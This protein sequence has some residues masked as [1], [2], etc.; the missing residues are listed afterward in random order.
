VAREGHPRIRDRDDDEGDDGEAKRDLGDPWL[1]ARRQRY[2]AARC[3]GGTMPTVAPLPDLVLYT[4]PG[5][6]LC[7][8][9]RESIQSVLEDRA[10][11]GLPCPAVVARDIETDPDLAATLRARV[12][13]VE[14][15]DR[16]LELA[17]S[18]SRIRRLL[19]DVLDAEMRLA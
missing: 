10:A 14:L 13:V 3:R 9:A 17:V 16:R 15:G 18:P 4:R 12:P 5:C 11:R 19:A 8:E 2:R 7:D 6:E 1:A